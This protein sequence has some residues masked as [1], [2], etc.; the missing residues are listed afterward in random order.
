MKKLLLVIIIPYLVLLGIVFYIYFGPG[1]FTG[2]ENLKWKDI[3]TNIPKS[4][5]S[6]SYENDGW[7]VYSMQKVFE[8]IKIARK[9]PAVDVS[10]FP[11]HKHAGK[12]L[13]QYSPGAGS[14]YY[15]SRVRKTHEVVFAGN[16]DDVTLYFSVATASVFSGTHLMDKMLAN[17]FYNGQKIAAPKPVIP[18]GAYVTDFIFL[19]GMT[20]PLIIIVLVFSLSARKPAPK[21][22]SGDPIQ[23]EENNVS[24]TRIQKWRRKNSFCYLVLTTSRLMIFMFGKPVLQISLYEEKPE[25]SFEGKKIVIRRPQEKLVLKPA[26]IEKWKNALIPFFS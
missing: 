3:E 11:K 20:I 21:Y 16:I 12:I 19:G 26:N 7:E 18:L 1:I 5:N 24:F 25:I 23:L 2:Y 13:Y 10:G 4:F 14:I 9:A 6:K 17:C 22:F 15:I 8:L